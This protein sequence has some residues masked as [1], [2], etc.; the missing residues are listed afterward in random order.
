M[1]GIDNNKGDEGNE[2]RQPP[3]VLAAWVGELLAEVRATH[4]RHLSQLRVRLQSDAF[5]WD[6]SAIAQAISA[7]HSAGRELHLRQLRQG[8]LD[9]LL[10]RHK[11]VYARFVAAYDRIVACAARLKAEAAELAASA[12]T[13]HTGA[14]RVLVDLDMELNALQAEL[15]RGVGWLQDMCTQLADAA[16]AGRAEPQFAQCAES[17]QVFTAQFKGL[18]SLCSI[19]REIRVRGNDVLVRRAALL[20]QVRADVEAFEKAWMRA[21]AKVVTDARAGRD[22]ARAAARMLETHDE[23]MK[24]LS[25]SADACSALTHEEHLVAQQLLLLRQEIAGLG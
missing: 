18:Q 23:L 24:R 22:P 14:T 21:V 13:H 7:V 1:Q 11:A 15:D 16:K 4:V 5:E 10:G 9:K 3:H 2:E 6:N 20:E 12:K 17:A 19:G 8:W 25:L